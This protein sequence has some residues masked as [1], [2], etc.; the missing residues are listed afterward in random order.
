VLDAIVDADDRPCFLEVNS[1]PQG[2]PDAYAQMLDDL[3]GV[4]PR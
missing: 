1:N 3:F 2:H 4:E